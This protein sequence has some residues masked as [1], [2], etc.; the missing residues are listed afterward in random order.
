MIDMDNFANKL[1]E[2]VMRDTVL[3]MLQDDVIEP[4]LTVA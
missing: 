4:L 1:A 2:S 3:S